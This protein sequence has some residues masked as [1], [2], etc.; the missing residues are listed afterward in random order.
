MNAN[1]MT[2]KIEMSQKEAKEA[3]KLNTEKFNELRNY[4]AMYPGFEIQIKAPARRKVEFRGLDYK[5]MREYIR[6]HDD[7]KGTIMAEFNTLIAQDKKDHKEGAEYLEATGYLAVR[8]WFLAKFPKIKQY[9][10]DHQQ[11]IQ[12]ILNVA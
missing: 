3:G 1:L 8:D 11:K 2:K 7:E 10:E 6:N 4:M 12:E 5:Y 9:K